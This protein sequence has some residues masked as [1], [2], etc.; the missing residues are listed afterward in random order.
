MADVSEPSVRGLRGPFVVC[1]A[2]A[3]ALQAGCAEGGGVGA[4]GSGGALGGGGADDGPSS[5]GSAPQGS[6]GSHGCFSTESTCDGLC[7]DVKTHPEHCGECNHPCAGGP[8]QA[9]ACVDGQCVGSCAAGFLDDQGTCKNFFGA[10][11]SYPAECAACSV[12]NPYSGGCACPA[13]T[14]AIPLH[15]QSDC[16]G[17]PLRSATT[18]Q[19]CATAGVSPDS[20]F[21]GAYEL[22]DFDGLCGAMPGSCRV[23]NPMAGNTCACPAGFEPITMRSI[24]RLPCDNTEVGAVV[25]LCGNKNVPLTTF[26]GAYQYDD[27]APNCRVTNPWTNDCTCPEGAVDRAYRVMVDGAQGLYGSTMHLCTAL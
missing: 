5:G 18:L 22:D 23:G 8:N 4:E 20:D 15:V 12:A 9:G 11:E 2:L 16:P 17:M 21:G 24:I 13:Q 27:F 1:V 6:G 3:A 7:V 25:V 10:H 19:L 26:G 14:T